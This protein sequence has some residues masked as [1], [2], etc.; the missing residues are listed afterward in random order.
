VSEQEEVLDAVG[1]SRMVTLIGLGGVGKTRLALWVGSRLIADHAD[2]VW[3]C[4]LASATDADAVSN[5]IASS[6][7]V[8]ARPG[9][10]LL[11]AVASSL[12]SRE[13][14]LLLDNCEHVLDAARAAAETILRVC[15]SVCVLATSR[16]PLGVPGE[17]LMPVGSLTTPRLPRIDDR[18][19]KP[20]E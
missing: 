19:A 17:V 9:L 15:P 4:E 16:E 8:T 11:D 13:L 10:T 20:G 12:R 14:V 6:L 3:L 2:G 7:G 5:V 18:G 1:R